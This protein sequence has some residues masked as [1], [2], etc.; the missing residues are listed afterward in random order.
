MAPRLL[1]TA[2][3]A[4]LCCQQPGPQ[5]ASG[6]AAGELRQDRYNVLFL[7]IDDL[8]PELGCYDVDYVRTPHI[9]ALAARGM[10]FLN[11]YAE[12]PTC[13]ASRYALLTGR[14]ATHSGVRRGNEVL[15]HGPAA[16]VPESLDGAQ[17][18]P[19][20]F[21]RSGYHTTLIGKL[22]HTPD[23]RVYAYDGSGDGRAELPQAW[24][25]FATPYGAWQRGWGSFFAYA[26]GAH[27]EDGGGHREL[28]QFTA[29]RD[30]DLPDG[31]MA[32]EAERRLAALAA[33]EEPFFL[34]VG[35]YKPHLPFVATRADWQA[36]QDWP[37]PAPQHEGLADSPYATR[38][39]EFYGYQFPFEKTRPLDEASTRTA[40]LAYLACVR[41]VDRQV[42]RVLAALDAN[43]LA[44]N[45]VVV[46]WG[47][48]GWYLGEDAMWGKHTPL[49]RAMHS[50]LIVCA[51]GVGVAGQ[52]TTA[53]VS[54]LDVY[55]TLVE[56]CAPEDRRTAHPLDGVSLLPLLRGEELA[57]HD[58]VEGWWGDVRTVRTPSG[59][60]FY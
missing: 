59:R 39:G 49:E 50:P 40:R 60:A 18:L 12:V 6:A 13:G 26:D 54:S 30:E 16:L 2:L 46:L 23:G 14:S 36:V 11:H 5:S 28:M 43:G 52:R 35:F 31:L 58:A 51:P 32:A 20:L 3:L 55:P 44:D 27:R 48:H 8:R 22:S 29:E 7:A 9:D 1:S 10:V 53:L 24:D 56:L 4:V 47:D 34:A 15:Y 57:V 19:E 17:S 42:G 33:A 25:D 45:T 37:L 38:S 41:Y 21:R